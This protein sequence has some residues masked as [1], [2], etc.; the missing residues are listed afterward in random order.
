MLAHL[1]DAN[2][3]PGHLDNAD[4]V[5]I[6]PGVVHSPLG[7]LIPRTEDLSH[8]DAQRLAMQV[9]CPVAVT[10]DGESEAV[11]H[12][13]SLARLSLD[14]PMSGVAERVGE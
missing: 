14:P 1:K 5:G 2:W 3:P 9:V 7:V 6:E 13:R 4:Q 11:T 10:G 8:D 12:V